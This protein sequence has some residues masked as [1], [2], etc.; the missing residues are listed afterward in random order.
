MDNREKH[1]LCIVTEVQYSKTTWCNDLIEGIHKEAIKRSITVLVRRENNLKTFPPGTV[2]VLVGSSLPFIYSCIGTC[3]RYDLRPLVAGFEVLQSNLN[4]S[5]VTI[6][7]RQS[8]VEM[9]RHLISCGAKRI[10]LL[11]VNSSIQTDMLRY[12]GWLNATKAYCI[13]NNEK[14]VYYSDNGSK[15]CIL[16][17]LSDYTMYDAVACTNDYF[18]IYLLA[19][20]VQRNIKVP[21]Q[22]MITGFGNIVL[23][24]YTTP[25][26]TTVDLNLTKLGME[27]VRVFRNLQNNPEM[28]SYTASLNSQIV[29]RATTNK[30]TIN[31]E[32][33]A[34]I[35]DSSETEFE[36]SFDEDLSIIH[37][38][39]KTV[40]NLDETDY[41]ILK[42]LINGIP[43][44][45]LS[46]N[47]FLSRTAF[48]YR[49]NKLF[50]STKSKS[51]SSL[52]ELLTKYIPS[53]F[54]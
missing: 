37:H 24:R 20:A 1:T 40:S 26:L 15:E 11:G 10:A 47:V 51:R 25:P 35:T 16:R 36:P 14:D 13:Y 32:R 28:L 6:N 43:Y 38:L 41:K 3:L 23:S 22:L 8:M 19:Q 4:V 53:Y 50:Y 49:L 30:E 54:D 48:Q 21:E 46:E 27:V 31:V 29:K 34:F 44:E 17:F 7:R 9:V 45:T 5:Y 33:K 42:G 12:E 39:E 2:V 52:V 18:A